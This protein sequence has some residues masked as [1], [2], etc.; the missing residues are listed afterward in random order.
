MNNN[1]LEWLFTRTNN[2]FISV[3]E[4]FL[5]DKKC[6]RELFTWLY[7][8][9]GTNYDDIS[10]KICLLLLECVAAELMR[11]HDDKLFENMRP[12]TKKELKEIRRQIRK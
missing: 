12:M 9:K 8:L 3:A 5:S 6:N 10:G 1:E 7:K 11:E 4:K 2:D